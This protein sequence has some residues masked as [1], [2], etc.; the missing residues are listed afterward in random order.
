MFNPNEIIFFTSFLLF[1]AM[2]L[3]IDLG[4][5]QKKN[6][7]LAFREALTWTLVWV[8]ISVGFYFLLRFHGNLIHGSD[9]IAEI[10]YKITKFHHPIDI[11]GLSVQ[12]AIHLYNKN[13]SL[14]YLTGYLIEYSLSV[15]NVFV[16]VLIFISF[17]I[18]P[19]YFKRVLFWGILGAVVMRFL[20]IFAA[21]ALIQR[22]SWTLYVFG[23]MLVII[24]L[25]MAWE[26]LYGK[27]GEQIDTEK[28]PVVRLVSRFFNVSQDEHAETFFI[29]QQGKLYVTPL[30]IVLMIIEFT[31]VLFAID[32][33]PAVF[34][35]TQDPYIVFFSNIFAILGLRSLFFLVMDIMNRFHYLKMGLAGLLTFV[36]TKMLLHSVFKISTNVSLIV[37]ASILVAS[38]LASNLRNMILKRKL[39]G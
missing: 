6:H 3:G 11:T 25:K 23:G 17:N 35:V 7:T 31:D 37:I 5:F 29:R 24:G 15:D 38:V 36:G 33:V 1:I 26:F 28:H 27:Q 30:F 32:S 39:R 19:K 21:S 4:F 22:F 13:L 2:M 8:G 18:Q 10:Q 34:S 14:E 20:F 9:T 12:D 16:I